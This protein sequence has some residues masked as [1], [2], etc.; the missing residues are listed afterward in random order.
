M[1]P[2]ASVKR[3]INA[4]QVRCN[5]KSHGCPWVGELVQLG[6]HLDVQKGDCD[7][8][9]VDCEFSDIGCTTKIQRKDVPQHREENVHKHLVLMVVSGSELEQVV[10]EQQAELIQKELQKKDEQIK[11]L[12]ERVHELEVFVRPL[13]FEF[14]MTEFSKQKANN[15]EWFSPPFYSHPGGYKQC[16]VVLANGNDSNKGTRLSSTPCTMQGEYDDTLTWPRTMEVNIELF[17]HNAGKWENELGCNT[18]QRKKP[19]TPRESCNCWHNISHT[20]LAPYL[21]NDCLLFRISRVILK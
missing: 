17:N 3:K 20:D 10:Q 8:V 2:D 1:F 15:T 11:L 19:T 12:Q 14:T 5:L 16:L 6:P 18:G 21:K 13:P 7:F 4:L 9:E